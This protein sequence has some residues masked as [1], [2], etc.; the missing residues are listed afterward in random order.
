MKTFLN[1]VVPKP[2]ESLYSFLFRTA[3][4]NYYIHLGSALKEI[5]PTIYCFNCN[6]VDEKK[7]WYNSLMKMVQ[8]TGR[9]YDGLSLNQYDDL[10][11]Q[12]KTL[13]K[14]QERFLYHL[15]GSKYCPDCLKED[16]YHRLYWD[17]TFVTVCTKHK[18]YLFELCP[19]C[20]KKTRTSRI[21]QNKC[22]CGHRFTESENK[23]QIPSQLEIDAQKVIQAL[24]LG[25]RKNIKV[26][27]IDI[28][29]KE[30][31]F[32]FFIL[33]CHL[34]DNLKVEGLFSINYNRTYFN[35]G[36]K[37]NEKK[38]VLSMSVLSTFVHLLIARP[39]DYLPLV[40]KRLDDTT[41]VKKQTKKYKLKFFYK[42]INDEV[43]DIYKKIYKDYLGNTNGYYV[44][45]KKYVQIGVDEKRYITFEEVTSTY[46]IPRRRLKFLC[47]RKQLKEIKQNNVRL[48]DKESVQHY[49]EMMKS[50]LNKNQ[51]AKIIGISSERIIDLAIKGKLKAQHGPKID[52]CHF[53]SFLKQDVEETLDWIL[54]KCMIVDEVPVGYVPFKEANFSLRHIGIDTIKL[55]ELVA[56]GMLQSI[57]LKNIPNVKGIYINKNDINKLIELERQKRIERWGYT[58]KESAE[59]LDIDVRKLKK[60][61]L[62][63]DIQTSFMRVNPNGT[64]TYFLDTSLVENFHID[65]R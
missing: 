31:Y 22:T 62:N 43:G 46:Q 4:S 9:N 14:Q 37:C 17:L 41:Q 32:R 23:Y 12:D 36:M 33:F 38:D 15:T 48:I 45:L 55:I 42:L 65:S 28:L 11:I 5:G 16:L 25:D 60:W 35:Y 27:N 2:N 29:T 3:I 18:K 49:L 7:T 63:G 44:N 13:G 50:A 6:Y 51:A 53:W 1:K 64:C 40:L 26:E 59:I 34:L 54:S 21:M 20:Y 56:E 47:N 8:M 24:L 52:G 39:K 61:V 57:I 58:L 30:D 19:V 10:L